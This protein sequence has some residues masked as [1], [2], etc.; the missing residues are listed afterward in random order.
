V[1]SLPAAGYVKAIRV[2]TEDALETPIDFTGGSAGVEITVVV[3]MNAGQI[4]GTVQNDK[5]EKASGGFAVLIP[6]GNRR[7]S[8]RVYR[9]A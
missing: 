5:S 7:E 1:I 8:D 3:A 9:T 4:T 2:G 6:E